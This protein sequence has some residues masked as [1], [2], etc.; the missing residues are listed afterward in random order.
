MLAEVEDQVSSTPGRVYIETYGCQQNVNDSEIVL[1]ILQAHGHQHC[2][3]LEEADVVLLNTCSIREQAEDRVWQRLHTIEHTFKKRREHDRASVKPIVAVLGCMAERLKSRLLEDKKLVDVVAGP[4][5]YRD[6]PFLINSRK[7]SGMSSMNVQLSLDETYAD[8][9]PVRI[10]GSGVSAFVSIQRG[11]NNMCSFCVVPFTRGRERSRPVSSILDEVRVLVDHGYKEVTLLGQNVNSYA[12]RS[13]PAD[14]HSPRKT[15]AGFTP[16]WK[17]RF[18]GALRFADLLDAVARAAPDMRIR[19][20]SPHPQ[21]FPDE[22]LHVIA[23]HA[24]ICNALHLPA[25]SGSSSVLHR[26]R[27]GYTREAYDDLLARARALIPGLFVSTDLIAGFCGET[28]EEHQ[29]TVDLVQRSSFD[30]AFMFHYSLREKTHAHRHYQDDVPSDVKLA[31]LNEIIRS[32]QVSLDAKLQ[33]Y[34]GTE[35]TL[36]V[37]GRS[38]KDPALLH[39][40]TDGGRLVVFPQPGHVQ[41]GQYVRVRVTGR[42]GSLVGEALESINEVAERAFV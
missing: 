28:D 27:R 37:H 34:I 8:I 29:Q 13:V 20:T 33:Q 38:E 39:G 6:L 5:A 25:Q 36:L 23:A 16:I 12:D 18:E 17:E 10:G 21:W 7:V 15:S 2:A 24:N 22:L 41:A 9:A 3:V 4:D 31:R 26:M 35:H 19:F 42:K 1:G 30:K 40:L 32:F 11:C 14:S